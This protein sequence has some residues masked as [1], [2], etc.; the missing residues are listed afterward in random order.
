M[1]RRRPQNELTFTV[2]GAA[3]PAGSK[4]AFRHAHTG[5]VL[6]AD[7]N[8][9]S[10]PW[11]REVADAAATAMLSH[12]ITE[13]GT[14]VDGPLSVRMIFY[15][16]RPQGH[17]G[18]KGLR[19]SA[20]PYPTKRPDVLKLARGVEDAMTGI[21]YRDDAQIVREQLVKDYG[22]PARVEVTVESL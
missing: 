19:P 9:K 16:P 11:K 2:Y 4:R 17:Y 6:V 8:K 22:E 5:A 3:Q 20:P 10:K 14:L 12:A 15:V 18:A 21:V 13:N 7:A 1:A